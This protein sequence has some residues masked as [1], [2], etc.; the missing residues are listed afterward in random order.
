MTQEHREFYKKFRKDLGVTTSAKSFYM[1]IDEIA[2]L[3]KWVEEYIHLRYMTNHY[4]TVVTEYKL[5]NGIRFRLWP[6][7][8]PTH[9]AVAIVI[10]RKY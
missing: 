5:T 7:T 9:R 2:R 6:Y 4:G 3:E 8:T 1:S 10:P